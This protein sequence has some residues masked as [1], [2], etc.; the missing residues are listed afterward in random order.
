MTLHDRLKALRKESGL[1]QTEIVEYMNN[2]GFSV[3]GYTISR[4]ESGVRKPSV[5][6]FF[7]LCDLYKISDVRLAFTG[8]PG[9]PTQEILLDGLNADGKAHARKY[10][11]MLRDDPLFT[12]KKPSAE[13]RVFRLYD[14]PVSAGSGMY[15][16]SADFAEITAEDLIPDDASYAVR[17]RGDSMEP[18]YYDDQIVFIREQPSI[19]VGEIGIFALNGESY[20]KRLG[21][22]KLISL[23]AKYEP[24]VIGE[25]DELRVCAKLLVL[26]RIDMYEK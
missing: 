4:W 16:D 8:V 11:N 5:E 12:I 6:E 21:D 2:K 25:D 18:K 17:V 15:L 26:I 10:V 14:I 23:N 22:G 9:I 1:K 3:H 13:P 7:A 24:I 20:I 19:N